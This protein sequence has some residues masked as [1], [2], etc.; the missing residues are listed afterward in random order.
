MATPAPTQGPLE[1]A[2]EERSPEQQYAIVELGGYSLAVPVARASQILE[3]PPITPVPNTPGFI[4]GVCNIRGDVL[5]V[6]DIRPL[7]GLSLAD[8]EARPDPLIILLRGEKYTCAATIEGISELLWV[9]ESQIVAPT[10]DIPFVSGLYRRGQDTILV[11]DVD[12]LL[13][14]PEMTQFQ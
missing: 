7:L 10:T 12:E 4:L 3:R 5:S 11:L 2:V 8:Q 14:S 1:P 9:R 6:V 13:G